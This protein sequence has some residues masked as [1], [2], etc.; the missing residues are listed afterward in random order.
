[1]GNIAYKRGIK[2]HWDAANRRFDDAK[3]NKLLK[4]TY[5]NGYQLPKI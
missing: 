2:L 4:P 3:A 1:M 5:H